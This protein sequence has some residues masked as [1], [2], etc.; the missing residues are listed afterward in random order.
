MTHASQ[1]D[2]SN[3]KMNWI[4]RAALSS[5]G[6]RSY[7]ARCPGTRCRTLAFD[8]EGQQW[9]DKACRKV[10]RVNTTVVLERHPG[11]GGGVL[12]ITDCQKQ[13]VA[14][15]E[16]TAGGDSRQCLQCSDKKCISIPTP[17]YYMF[18]VHLQTGRDEVRSLG[19]CR[20]SLCCMITSAH[21]IVFQAHYWLPSK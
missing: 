19:A 13:G 9:E 20:L 17:C 10:G 1:S 11:C 18:E 5:A 3:T 16:R 14:L 7:S 4:G 12:S 2:K 6:I 21:P 15:E 8:C